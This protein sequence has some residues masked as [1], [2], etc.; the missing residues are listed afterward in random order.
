MRFTLIQML[1][2]SVVLGLILLGVVGGYGLKLSKQIKPPEAQNNYPLQRIVRY[3]IQVRNA[4]PKP[5]ENKVIR[6]LA[7]YPQTATQKRVDLRAD[8]PYELVKDASGNDWLV[9]PMA[10]IA[11][12]GKKHLTLTVQLGLTNDPTAQALSEKER[13]HYLAAEQYIEVNDLAIQK[14]AAELKRAEPH[15]TARAVLQ[16]VRDNLSYSGYIREPRGARYALI[17]KRGDCTEYAYLFTALMRA[18]QIP[19]RVLRGYVMEQDG[20]L[21]PT[22]VHDWSEYY[23]EGRWHLVD[24]QRG[25]LRSRQSHYLAMRIVDYREHEQNIEADRLIQGDTGLEVSQL[26]VGE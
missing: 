20:L 10:F 23:H 2:A 16:A 12:L 13:E 4:E 24:P 15:A 21:D 26:R 9:F 8:Q 11:P 1:I 14:R 19:S 3:Q 6:V 17:E 7:P 25:V 22:E 18:N 5:Q